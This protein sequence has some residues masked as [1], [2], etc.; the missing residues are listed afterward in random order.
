VSTQREKANKLISEAKKVVSVLDKA[1]TILVLKNYYKGWNDTGIAI[2]R[3]SRVGKY[4]YMGWADAAYSHFDG[5][6]KQISEQHQ[7][8]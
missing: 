1:F 3:D 6:C 8:A 5:L 4:Q 2:W 7:S